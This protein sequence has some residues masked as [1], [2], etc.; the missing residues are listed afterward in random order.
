MEFYVEQKVLDLGVKII[1]VEIDGIDNKTISDEYLQWRK[2]EVGV[3]LEK[4]K[5]FDVKRDEVLEA[6]YTL[7]EKVNVPRRK[8]IP[9]SENLIKLLIKKQGLFEINKAVDIYNIIS[10]ESKL[11]LGAHD[12]DKLSGNITLRLT[13]GTEKFRPLGSEEDKPVKPGEYSYIDDNNEILCWLEIRQ[14]EKDKVTEDSK[15]I[16]YIVQGNEKT[17]DDLLYETADRI[18]D[19][20]VRFCNGNGKILIPQIIGE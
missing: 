10:M 8:N 20:T 11:A 13:D 12:I 3:L 19:T 16:F 14:V 15:N 7:H 18:V 1:G 6:F 2:D 9:A 17:S 5:D 4:Y